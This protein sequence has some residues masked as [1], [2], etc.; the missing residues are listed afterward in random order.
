[1]GRSVLRARAKTNK[2]ISNLMVNRPPHK[3]NKLEGSWPD[4]LLLAASEEQLRQ[5]HVVLWHGAELVGVVL[6]CVQEGLQQ[7]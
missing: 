1:M 3:H 2:A 4:V 6:L 5:L 7:L